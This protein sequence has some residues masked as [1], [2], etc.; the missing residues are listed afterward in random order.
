MPAKPASLTLHRNRIEARRKK[1]VARTVATQT[2]RLVREKDIRAYA[3]VGLAADGS[4]YALWDTGAAI[5]VRALAPLFSE[6]LTTDIHN[7][8]ADGLKDDWRPALNPKGSS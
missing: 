8:M 4:V 1:D 2:L 5:P 7:A 3:F 6:V